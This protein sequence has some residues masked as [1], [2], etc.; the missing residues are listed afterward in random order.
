LFHYVVWCEDCCDEDFEGCFG[1]GTQDSRDYN[2]YEE[3][4]EAGRR[5][6]NGTLWSFEV[7][8]S[9]EGD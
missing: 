2:T 4:N 7:K 9:V 6:V 8:E 1:G 5:F 3:A